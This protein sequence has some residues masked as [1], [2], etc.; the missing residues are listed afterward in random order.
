M[1][2]SLLDKKHKIS[3]SNVFSGTS[4]TDYILESDIEQS[5]ITQNT[6]QATVILES[7]DAFILRELDLSIHGSFLN[8]TISGSSDGV[9][10]NYFPFKKNADGQILRLVS[11]WEENIILKDS[12]NGF[13]YKLVVDD[14]VLYISKVNLVQTSLV[15]DNLT[16]ND[17]VNGNSY[18]VYP[19]NGILITEL[20]AY[21]SGYPSSYDL[22]D[23][24]NTNK[25]SLVVTNAVV[26]LELAAID[27]DAPKGL[28]Y[29]NLETYEF[30]EEFLLAL[31]ETDYIVSK[32]NSYT[33]ETE[34]LLA[35]FFMN[36]IKIDFYGIEA[37]VNAPFYI[38]N[39]NFN[40]EEFFN[41]DS[42]NQEILKIRVQ[43][44]FRGK[45]Y[46]DYPFFMDIERTFADSLESDRTVY[47]T[48]SND[49]Y[50]QITKL[51]DYYAVDSQV[52][53]NFE[54]SPVLY[55]TE[56]Q[57]YEKADTPTINNVSDLVLENYVKMY[58]Y[59]LYPL[60]L[61]IQDRLTTDPGSFSEETKTYIKQFFIFFIKN[62]AFFNS[63]KGTV[64][65]LDTVLTFYSRVLGYYLVS[66]VETEKFV[67]RITSN[68]P[69]D[70]WESLL[71]PY[72]H[73]CSW[74]VYF[75][76]VDKS[77]YFYEAGN[78]N[79]KHL[80]TVNNF[81]KNCISYFEANFSKEHQVFVLEWL[82][83][84]F[85]PDTT[86][87]NI[88]FLNNRII[89]D[90]VISG[91]YYS[92]IIENG[93]VK[94][95]E[96]IITSTLEVS[97]IF[98]AD[99]ANGKQYQL[100]VES[101]LPK[102]QEVEPGT[103]DTSIA[104][105]LYEEP[106]ALYILLSE[107]GVLKLFSIDFDYLSKR[108]NRNFN[109]TEYGFSAYDKKKCF[110]VQ[111]SPFN[112]YTPDFLTEFDDPN[113]FVVSTTEVVPNVSQLE[114]EFLKT[115]FATNYIWNF[116]KNGTLVTKKQ[117][118]SNKVGLGVGT[119]VIE[120]FNDLIFQ[121]V[122]VTT[123]YY[124]FVLVGGVLIIEQVNPTLFPEITPITYFGM[125]DET[126]LLYYDIKIDNGFVVVVA[127]IGPYTDLYK[128]IRDDNSLFYKLL[129]RGGLLLTESY[130][131]VG[132]IPGDAIVFANNFFIKDTGSLVDTYYKLFTSNGSLGFQEFDI[133]YVDSISNIKT[134]L[135]FDDLSNTL[136]YNMKIVDGV[137][138][139]QETLDIGFDYYLLYDRVTPNYYRLSI[140]DGVAIVKETNIFN[141][142]YSVTGLTVKLDIQ[143]LNTSEI[144]SLTSEPALT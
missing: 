95:E 81:D 27:E 8:Y 94:L 143:N 58:L 135:V 136:H 129:I 109:L 2:I 1:I 89:E 141:E 104:Y 60:Y 92:I 16:I 41:L 107:N 44:F 50:N 22:F 72:L 12:L 128:L 59:D 15:I 45:M 130:A 106:N 56:K 133:S 53:Q 5:E 77:T 79:Y 52:S 36:F 4:D 34:Y 102:L 30:T 88:S 121:D 101:G 42:L 3:F 13:Y 138:V 21:N 142:L 140:L 116:Y 114:I 20:V 49:L 37:S 110:E 51:N 99:N 91:V 48:N 9:S 66:V 127:A 75:N 7:I 25:F 122:T 35:E 28:L 120:L 131:F 39:L 111:N 55:N 82:R 118:H 65:L 132:Y 115:G 86:Y 69:I 85:N 62:S 32:V 61:S 96:T 113:N 57:K 139:I 33:G 24:T 98:V 119:K 126:S 100:I 67:Y 18:L 54:F 29:L 40:I 68:I 71:K 11:D 125:Q 73:P 10:W 47:P 90:S 83:Q 93:V 23:T 112:F 137:M 97:D 6:D 38:S 43:D 144:K 123:N 103:A 80:E 17:T 78:T 63:L 124:K 76:E 14:A 31:N 87:S 26:S 19:E 134:L 64:Y 105:A 74:S 70:E 84:K 117:T 46:T 108:Y